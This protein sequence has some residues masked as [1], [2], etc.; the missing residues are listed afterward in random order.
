ME[1]NKAPVPTNQNRAPAKR[2]YG[3]YAPVPSSNAPSSY[4][5]GQ[6]ANNNA[7]SNEMQ[8]AYE[9]SSA[10]LRDR[11]GKEEKGEENLKILDGMVADDIIVVPGTYDHIHNVLTALK[12]SLEFHI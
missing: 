1:Q 5:Y 4:G 6:I 2:N 12:V 3:N 11:L 8:G 10:M 7:P 9:V